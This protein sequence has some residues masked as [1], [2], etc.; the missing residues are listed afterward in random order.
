M[1]QMVFVNWLSGEIN[2]PKN[3]YQPDKWATGMQ[4]RLPRW[5]QFDENIHK[6]CDNT[7]Q[8]GLFKD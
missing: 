7:S 2:E 8:L 3:K 4:L 5:K 1:P 6:K